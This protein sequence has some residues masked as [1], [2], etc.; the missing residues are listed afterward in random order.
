M[1]SYLWRYYLENDAER[2]QRLLQ[3]SRSGGHTSGLRASQKGPTSYGTSPG[4][5]VKVR[6]GSPPGG[7]QLSKQ[8]LRQLDS[9]GRSILHMACTEPKKL[10]FVRALLAHPFVDTAQA[11]LESGWTSLH[12]ALYNGNIS[13]AREIFA[14]NPSSWNLVKVKDAA[15]DTP[16][17][18]YGA[19]IQDLESIMIADALEEEAKIRDDD[20]DMEDEEQDHVT[21][22]ASKGDEIFSWGSNK[23]LTLGFSDGDDRSYPERVQL[24]RPREL[25]LEQAKQ[26]YGELPESK[27][28]SADDLLDASV[29]FRPLKISD[30]QLS[31]FHS[32]ILTEDEY[33][34]LHV[35]GFGNG[36]RLGFGGDQNTVFKYRPLTPPLLPKKRVLK[37]ALGM[38]HTVAVLEDGEV[39]TWGSNRW[40]QLGYGVPQ[41]TPQEEPIQMT[42]KQVQGLLK[43]E[44][45]IGC[46]ASRT[47]TAVFTKDSLF[48]FGKNDGQLG[49]LDSQEA[50]NLASQSSPRKVS[51]NFLTGVVIKNIVAIDT[52]TCVL[53]EGGEV[54]IFAG[55]AY[56]RLLFPVKSFVGLPDGAKNITRYDHGSNVIH[57]ITGGGDTICALS[58]SGDV[59]AVDVPSTLKERAEKGGSGRV[60]WI[61]QHAWS[62]RKRHMAVRD[63]DVSVEGN[64]IIATRSGSVWTRTRRVRPKEGSSEGGRFKFNRVPGLTRI[65]T[66]RSNAT[67][68]F[69]AI[70]QDTDVMEKALVV[71]PQGL[72]TEFMPL[73]WGKLI[74]Q[75]LEREFYSPWWNIDFYESAIKDL[76]ERAI[77]NLLDEFDFGDRAKDF[78]LLIGT[79]KVPELL[80]PT[81]IV[82]F[83]RSP[84]LRKL[85]AQGN[86]TINDIGKLSRRPDGKLEL[87]FQGI[88]LFTLLNLSLY[89]HTDKLIDPWCNASVNQSQ[90][91][92]YDAL[93]TGLLKLSEALKM[94][95]LSNSLRRWV[96]V[97]RSLD[98]DMK[99]AYKDPDFFKNSDMILDL[100]D[101]G[102]MRVHSS[103]MRA[104]C[105]FFKALY[106]DGGIG[107]GSRWLSNR[108]HAGESIHVDLTHIPKHIME[109][110]VSW[111]YYDWDTDGF[112]GTKEGVKEDDVDVFLDYILEV[113]SVANEL[114]LDRLNQIC[115]KIIGRYVNTRNAAGLLNVVAEC[116]QKGFKEAALRYVCLNM[117]TMLE[118]HLL[119][120]LDEDLMFDIDAVIHRHNA[121]STQAAID[122]QYARLLLQEPSLPEMQ[123][124][125]KEETIVRYTAEAEEYSLLLAFKPQSSTASPS[126]QSPSAKRKGK[127][128]AAPTPSSLKTPSKTSGN[129]DIFSMDAVDDGCDGDQISISAPSMTPPV[130]KPIPPPPAPP[131][132]ET[133]PSPAGTPQ[134]FFP[135]LGTST[136]YTPPRKQGGV[137]WTTTTPTKKLDMR[138]IMAQASSAASGRSG[139]TAALT[140]PP[141]STPAPP[142]ISTSS[143]SSSAQPAAPPTVPNSTA[144]TF[145][146]HQ[147]QKERKR[148][149]QLQHHQHP[150]SNT[151]SSTSQTPTKKSWNISTP[152]PAISLKDVLHPP[153]TSPPKPS[154]SP[155]LVVGP[156]NPS[157]SSSS[158]IT[159]PRRT[160]TTPLPATTTTAVSQASA[161]PHQSHQHK[162][163]HHHT[164][165]LTL[166]D[167]ITQEE[168]QKELVKEYA[169]KRSLQEIQEEQ[170]FMRWWERESKRVQG[171]HDEEEGESEKVEE[172]G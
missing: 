165:K 8:Q 172:A 44:V 162:N 13:V 109:V 122:N 87:V 93:R 103:V 62:M 140:N 120:E 40:G 143:S 60:S 153:P 36:G 157:P 151:T 132:F 92:R 41:R 1:S 130:W 168:A 18:V 43:R 139:I 170:E 7:L 72:W 10:E 129:D 147:S 96:R 73:Y 20:S 52:A 119:D 75:V 98:A 104:R 25:V 171:I 45:V 95:A 65:T 138:E 38:D 91:K 32:A 11:D 111:M 50:R 100:A 155:I 118:N 51:A 148:Q 164:I 131:A 34:N 58:T 156:S 33:A 152:A 89:L 126:T 39:W 112:N 77:R 29:L 69:A 82:P 28:K 110:V 136:P 106:A 5:T 114:M 127:Q 149:Q 14:T 35:C 26:K 83:A 56:S 123:A 84:V 76:S 47:H 78:G 90:R 102:S 133:S 74:P 137:P 167:I 85:L 66:V 12:R 17:D 19:I 9:M 145:K 2:F 22:D 128:P 79:T 158:S 105:Q 3:G 57:H 48:T 113:L 59:F 67:G 4:S 135:G 70:R 53:L 63:V 46:A 49:I 61:C 54:W 21:V 134:S 108:I 16:F 146:K 64:I 125:E 117:E 154:K 160:I 97:R 116:S 150:P 99:M 169:A 71:Q 68:G 6:P 27:G 86:G 88:G 42:P 142:T 141:T 24:K 23:N 15:G 166:Q 101:G 94:D 121:R 55:H 31:K 161:S 30:V 115:Q 163:K 159:T 144:P 107:G 81:H 37:V 124:S 80:I